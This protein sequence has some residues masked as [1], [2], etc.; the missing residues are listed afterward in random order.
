MEQ[1]ATRGPCL[2][3]ALVLVLLGLTVPAASPALAGYQSAS[4]IFDQSN[5]LGSGNYGTVHLEAYTG[6]A[7]SS[8]NG[9]LAGQVRF[10]V[11][12]P[13]LSIYGNPSRARNYGL[14]Q[15]AFNT[16]LSILASQI[17]VTT[18]GGTNLNWT[19]Q[20][21]RNVSSFGRFSILAKGTGKS[22]GNPIVVTISGLG[23]NATLNHFLFPSTGRNGGTYFAAHLGGFP[24]PP[25]SHFIGVSDVTCV[26]EP[27]SW[28][29][30]VVGL[31]GIGLARWRRRGTVAAPSA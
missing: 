15:F 6:P 12:A 9:L 20:F 4:F 22:R 29:L 26:P 7:G 2:A 28:M 8:F 1:T 25:N 24:C 30:A 27:A 18:T 31:T 10:T 16:D 23:D 3:P 21:N 13:F 14:D 19:T 5:V 17:V 11:T